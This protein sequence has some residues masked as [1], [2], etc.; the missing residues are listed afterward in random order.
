MKQP[1][2][3]PV[4]YARRCDKTG[5]GMNSG[6]LFGDGA[7]YIKY[8]E[9][10]IAELRGPNWKD[11]WTDM[12]PPSERTDDEV[13]DA[14]FEQD[15]C[16]WTEWD[17]S[18]E[19]EWYTAHGCLLDTKERVSLYTQELP[20]TD[21]EIAAV[22]LKM[23]GFMVWVREGDDTRGKWA[24]KQT[25]GVNVWQDDLQDSTG[26]EISDREVSDWARV[27][28]EG[29]LSETEDKKFWEIA[30]QPNEWR[31]IGWRQI[32]AEHGSMTAR[33]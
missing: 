11:F 10:V 15:I 30:K 27:Y 29:M 16:Y 13:L 20:A 32:Y 28:H 17:P 14:A 22:L 5:E 7:M 25:L 18:E 1:I 21:V 3:T 19:D 9:D 2:T 26:M 8:K 6:W 23:R 33:Q 4:V 12:K 24:G 31:F